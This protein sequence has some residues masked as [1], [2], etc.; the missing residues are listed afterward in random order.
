MKLK[1]S[2]NRKIGELFLT[3]MTNQL[4]F[5]EQGATWEGREASSATRALEGLG[6]NSNDT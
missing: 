2:I 4:Q 3:K 1:K 6:H 5:N